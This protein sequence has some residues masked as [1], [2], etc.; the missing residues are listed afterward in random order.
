VDIA[1]YLEGK[2]N[3]RNGIY[4]ANSGLGPAII[5]AVS[6]EVGG[7]SY[8]AM[9]KH[10]WQNVFHD[11]KIN[12]FC[13]RRGWIGVLKP[14]EEFAILTITHANPPVVGEHLYS[15]ELLKFLKAEG[16]KVRLQYESL[17]GNPA[18][19]IRES[20]IDSDMIAEISTALMAQLAPKIVEQVQSTVVQLTQALGQMQDQMQQWRVDATKH[21]ADLGV[22][23]LLRELYEDPPGAPR[24]WWLPQRRSPMKP[25]D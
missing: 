17:Y 23:M 21:M 15:I 22:L 4:I 7:K 1:Y 14:G 25:Q 10:V 24:G 2:L 9:D 20:W 13:F 12:P 6:V 8:N 3:E 5:K 11:L 16:L 19:T 18:E